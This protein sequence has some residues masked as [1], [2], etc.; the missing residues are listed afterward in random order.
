MPP[1]ADLPTGGTLLDFYVDFEFHSKILQSLIGAL[2]NEAVRRMAHA[3]DQGKC[4]LQLQVDADGIARLHVAPEQHRLHP[5]A[6][7]HYMVGKMLE[8]VG[9]SLNDVQTTYIPFQTV[10][11]AMAKKEIDGACGQLAAAPDGAS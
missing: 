4:A 3:F 7:C 1:G 9:L 10:P 11:G 8:S 6:P 2:F 5:G